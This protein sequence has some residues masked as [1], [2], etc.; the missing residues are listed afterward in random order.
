MSDRSIS[1]R[2]M[3]HLVGAGGVGLVTASCVNTSDSTGGGAGQPARP[4]SSTAFD[5][6][7]ATTKLPSGNVRL[8]WMDSGDMKARFFEKFFPAY[9]KKHPNISVKYDGTNWNQ[10]TQVVT[11]GVRNGTVP[12]VFQLPGQITMGMAVSNGWI[13]AYDDIIPDFDKVKARY[14]GY[15]FA[16]GV[17]DFGGKTYAMPLTGNGRINNLLLFNRDLVK[18]V[19]ADLANEVITWSKLREVCKTV[20][21]QGSGK[22]YG[23]IFGLAQPGGLA[24][25]VSTLCEM[26]GVHGGADGIDWRTGKYNV[27]NPIVVEAIELMLAIRKDGSAHPD[28]VNLDAPGARSRMPLG[29]AGMMFQ[30]PWNIV[31]WRED[32]PD[33]HLGLNIPPQKNPEDIW[34]LAFG[35]GG[36]NSWVYSS[37]TKLGPVIGDIMSYLSSA[38]GQV[39]WADY[40]GAAD[41]PSFPDAIKKAKLDDLQQK[42]MDLG[43]K[44]TVIRPEP[45]VRNPDVS[46]VYEVQVPAQ[47]SFSDTLV[48][49][50]TGRIGGS[51]EKAMKQMEDRLEKSL[52]DA[53]KK[54]ASRGAKVSRDDWVFEDWNP[55]A[56]YTKL[57]QD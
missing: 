45:A 18:D 30:G 38:T 16:P 46:K 26:A 27:T 1:R 9:Q 7:A 19:G 3:L 6:P 54:A 41:P 22:Y 21:K 11:L 55:R 23:I 53:I 29:Q 44:H 56:P 12:D 10:I 35:P 39:R 14:P 52:E 40:D 8:R 13:G 57:Y 36:S 34:P 17:T 43:A 47:P 20:T 24:G 4:K 50:Y 28:S 31:A 33:F 48:G 15:S 49:L 37:K 32:N 2:R 25:P 42:A 5:I 51:V